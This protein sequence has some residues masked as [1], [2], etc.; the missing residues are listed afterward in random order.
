MQLK[1]IVS[2]IF[3]MIFR[4]L[5][6]IIMIMLV[7]RLA[8]AAYGFGYDVF[9]DAPMSA[10]PGLSKTVT[11]AEGTGKWDMAKLLEEKGVV[12]SA[13]VFYVQLMLSDYKDDWKPGIYE[14]N[15]S[16]H[17]EEIILLLAGVSEEEEQNGDS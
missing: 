8:V 17:A 6:T 9:L 10:S 12:K 5:V 7:Y 14:L 1:Q 11:I 15:T 3:G 2:A 13:G 16:M 4:L